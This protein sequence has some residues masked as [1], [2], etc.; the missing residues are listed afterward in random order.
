[1]TAADRIANLPAVP[2]DGE[3]YLPAGEVA[4]IF[5]VTPRTVTR[6]TYTG[7]LPYIRT[8]GGQRRIPASAIQALMIVAR[9]DGGDA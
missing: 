6:W 7:K 5:R 8:L 3:S 1:M 4:R 9:H 2:A